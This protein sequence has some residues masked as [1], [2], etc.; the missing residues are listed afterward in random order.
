MHA[1]RGCG[2][3]VEVEAAPATWATTLGQVAAE[4]QRRAVVVASRSGSSTSVVQRAGAWST[5]AAGEAERGAEPRAIW[6]A[7]K[8]GR[9]IA[10]ELEREAARV[11]L[12]AGPARAAPGGGGSRWGF[13]G[14]VGSVLAAVGVGMWGAET[15]G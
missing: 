6:E 1:L 12:G 11:G 9:V 8:R 10:A 13:A 15:D 3:L 14:V 5:A 7:L 2:G 4:V